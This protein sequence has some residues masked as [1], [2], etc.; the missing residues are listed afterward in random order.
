MAESYLSALKNLKSLYLPELLSGASPAYHR[1]I[2]R[3][4]NAQQMIHNLNRKGVGARRPVFK[5]LH[6]YFGL[7]G[8][9]GTEMLHQQAVSIP[10]YP[11]LK[12]SDQKKVIQ[13][14]QESV[15]KA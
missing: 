8:F 3:V 13:A 6:R 11:S 4:K 15:E 7:K 2:F 10:I 9:P 1:F 12:L 5:P 14:V